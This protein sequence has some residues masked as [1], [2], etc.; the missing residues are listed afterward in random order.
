MTVAGGCARGGRMVAGEPRPRVSRLVVGRRRAEYADRSVS[1]IR[2]RGG[3]CAAA[4]VGIVHR[5]PLSPAAA[6]V[7]ARRCVYA[8]GPDPT[9]G[10][11]SNRRSRRALGSRGNSTYGAFLFPY[12]IHSSDCVCA[13]GCPCRFA[14]HF[15]VFVR[16][17]TYAH[18]ERVCW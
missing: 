7:I 10:G 6:F 17:C 16:R 12:P 8:V 14:K 9:R 3:G 1:S 13:T 2:A 4:V 5:N 18:Y 11:R 15:S